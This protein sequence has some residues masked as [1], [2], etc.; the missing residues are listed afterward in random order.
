MA[1]WIKVEKIT[2]DKPEVLQL[3]ELLQTTQAEAFLLVFRFWSWVDDMSHDC[4]A[5]R[6]T[7]VTLD[8]MMKA[9]GFCAAMQKVGWLDVEEDFVIIP[10]FERHL[11]KSAKRRA[12]ERNRQAAHREDVT[13]M[14]RAERD[15]KRTR[16]RDRKRSINS[17]TGTGEAGAGAEIERAPDDRAKIIHSHPGLAELATEHVPA[18]AVRAL[19]DGAFKVIK[20]RHLS[21]PEM[22]AEWFQRQL[23]LPV[24]IVPG[25]KADLAMVLSLAKYAAK[26]PESEV[27]KSRSAAFVHFVSSGYWQKSLSHITWAIE[28]VRTQKFEQFPNGVAPMAQGAIADGS[29]DT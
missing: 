4:H 6:V 13:D 19:L 9:D 24:P 10:N 11:S 22:I 1:D 2:P 18:L 20:D 3:S 15:E 14:S 28:F 25:T 5:A 12:L 27:R 17:G 29:D 21:N 7:F 23:S 26:M 8:R 16:D